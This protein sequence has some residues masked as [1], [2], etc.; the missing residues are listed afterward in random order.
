[1]AFVNSVCQILLILILNVNVKKLKTSILF[2]PRSAL[3]GSAGPQLMEWQLEDVPQ[4]HS[5]DPGYLMEEPGMDHLPGTAWLCLN[6]PL[7]QL[8]TMPPR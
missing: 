7:E 2:Q 3:G 5:V 1:M 8:V 4:A 6:W